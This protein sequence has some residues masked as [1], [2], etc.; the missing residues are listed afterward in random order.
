MLNFPL[1]ILLFSSEA[2]TKSQPVTARVIDICLPLSFIRT[3]RIRKRG[4][5]KKLFLPLAYTFV[6]RD[7]I[8][9]FSS[10]IKGSITFVINNLASAKRN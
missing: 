10:Y 9:T 8:L 4:R 2:V 1:A 5:K 3:I 7:E 6:P